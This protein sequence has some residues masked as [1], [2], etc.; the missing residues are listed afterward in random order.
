MNAGRGIKHGKIKGKSKN[1][2]SLDKKQNC[3]SSHGL[4][5]LVG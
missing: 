4:F 3:R 5:S 2:E 1:Q